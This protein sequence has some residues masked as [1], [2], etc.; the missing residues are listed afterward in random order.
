MVSNPLSNLGLSTEAY[1]DQSTSG[2]EEE[3]PIALT[4]VPLRHLSRKYFLCITW[5]WELIGYLVRR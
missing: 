2:V 4:V 1:Y 3:S 5:I